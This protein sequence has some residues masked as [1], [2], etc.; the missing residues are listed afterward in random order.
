[1]EPEMLWCAGL[2][3]ALL[4]YESEMRSRDRSALPTDAR[5]L[6]PPEISP[7]RAIAGTPG[8]MIQAVSVENPQGEGV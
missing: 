1:M 6:S 5:P 4:L 7:A 3:R 8:S 2:R